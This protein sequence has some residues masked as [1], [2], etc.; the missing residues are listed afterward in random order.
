MS[1]CCLL[2]QFLRM[3]YRTDSRTDIHVSHDEILNVLNILCKFV[4]RNVFTNEID[5]LEKI[6]PLSSSSSLI[7]LSP[8]LD[9]QHLVRVGGRLRNSSLSYNSRHPI[10]LPKNHR[11]TQLIIRQE[12]IRNLHA[13]LQ[14]TITAVKQ[15]FWP[16]SIR[17]VTR[18]IIRQCLT[19]FKCKPSFS[20]AKMGMLSLSRVTPFRPFSKCGVDYADPVILR[21]S[22]RRNACNNKVYI[23]IFV[24]FATKEIHIEL[25]IYLL[26]PFWLH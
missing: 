2:Q 18:R 7:S 10:L 12:H 8:F 20:E 15:N 21:E 16:C 11:L 17:S 23:C 22:K 1:N 25:V 14:G 5:Q 3:L 24:C 4:Q 6:I 26:N 19:C 9:D 13:G